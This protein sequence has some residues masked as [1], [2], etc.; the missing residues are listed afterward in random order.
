MNKQVYA[1][2]LENLIT[3]HKA[4]CGIYFS[5]DLFDRDYDSLSKKYCNNANI[6][7]SFVTHNPDKLELTEELANWVVGTYNEEFYELVED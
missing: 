3:G 1:L 6:I 5:P 7:L 2:Y 4:L